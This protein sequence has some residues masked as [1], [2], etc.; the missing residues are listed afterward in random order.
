MKDTKKRDLFMRARGGQ[1]TSTF[2]EAAFKWRYKNDSGI[3]RIK[4]DVR[5]VLAGGQPPDYGV[6]YAQEQLKPPPRIRQH[7]RPSKQPFRGPAMAD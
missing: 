7:A 6:E 2:L 3:G 4:E 5:I 1:N